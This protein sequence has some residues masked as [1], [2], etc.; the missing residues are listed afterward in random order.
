MRKAITRDRAPLVS[1]IEGSENLTRE[2]KDCALELL[3]IY[4]NPLGYVCYGKAALASGVYEIYWILV[5]AGHQRKGIGQRLIRHI[6][7]VVKDEGARMLV[8]ETSG[9]P[10]Y[11]GVRSFYRSCGYTEEARIR[12]FF[13]PGDDKVIYAK[14]L[15]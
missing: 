11:E 9:Q 10:S 8:V 4:F 1:I 14:D 3:D 15:Y 6:E 2:E 13:R 7:S 5:G 12:G